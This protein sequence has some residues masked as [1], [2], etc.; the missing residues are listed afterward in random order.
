MAEHFTGFLIHGN[1]SCRPATDTNTQAHRHNRDSDIRCPYDDLVIRA[2]QLRELIAFSKIADALDTDRGA[3]SLPPAG[4]W[5]LA[6]VVDLGGQ[7]RGG[8]AISVSPGGVDPRPR[9]DRS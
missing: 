1:C 3:G 7:L 9:T 2:P 5:L 8:S 6:A 4:R